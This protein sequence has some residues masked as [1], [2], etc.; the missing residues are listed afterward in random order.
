M[1]KSVHELWHGKITIFEL[2]PGLAARDENSRDRGE[3]RLFL[4]QI[5]GER[6]GWLSYDAFTPKGEF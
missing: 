4:G 1:Q 6:R 2:P 5:P 3:Q